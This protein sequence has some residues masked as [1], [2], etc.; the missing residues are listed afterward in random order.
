MEGI[1]DVYLFGDGGEMS[2]IE[3]LDEGDWSGWRRLRAEDRRT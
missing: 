1:R 2:R 3:R